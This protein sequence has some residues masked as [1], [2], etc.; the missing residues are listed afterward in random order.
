M[1]GYSLSN[2]NVLEYHVAQFHIGFKRFFF[3]GILRYFFPNSM[4]QVENV[5]INLRQCQ[6]LKVT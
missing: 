5:R 3:K 2:F 4:R 6:V 1:T